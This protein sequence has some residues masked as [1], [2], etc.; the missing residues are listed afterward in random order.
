MALRI[1]SKKLIRCLLLVIVANMITQV[2]FSQSVGQISGGQCVGNT[3][4][5]LFTGS[6]TVSSWD[7]S[8]TPTILFTS[9]DKKNIQVKWS[10]A[11]IKSVSVNFSGCAA[12][13]LSP[14]RTSVTLINAVVPTLS[15]TL[16]R[17]TT[18]CPQGQVTFT[19]SGQNH[20]AANY[21]W[22]VDG[23]S[24]GGG[25][26][27]SYI[28]TTNLPSGSH[29]VYCKMTS[30]A[31][32]ADP[33][34]VSTELNPTS[35][36]VP[37][38][39]NYNVTV[40]GQG[41]ICS[42]NLVQSFFA[43]VENK[44]PGASYQWYNTGTPID[45]L[46]N[47]TSITENLRD[48]T[49][50][51]GDIITC[52]VSYSDPAN[53]CTFSK[54]SDSYLVNPISSPSPVVGINVERLEF[55]SDETIKFTS[56]KTA[57][58]YEWKIN[59]TN[60][61][62]AREAYLP[63]I[64]LGTSFVTLTV[65][66]LIE[67]CLSLPNSA[68]AS[69][70]GAP[71]KVFSRPDA[72]ASNQIIC[73]GDTFSSLVTNPNGVIGTFYTWSVTQDNVTGAIGGGGT[74]LSQPISQTLAN[75]NGLI[76]GKATYTIIP[77][78]NSCQGV[79]VTF[80]VTVQPMADLACLNENFIITN[81]LLIKDIIN[82]SSIV[83]LT[84]DQL[85]QSIQY[86]DGIGRQIQLVNTQGSPQKNDLVQPM[87]YDPLGR[88][89]FR[90]LPYVSSTGKSGSIKLDFIPKEDANYSTL[91]N[92][93]YKFYQTTP[94]IAF[95]AKPYSETVFEPSPLNRVLKQ[96]SP[97]DVW[98]PT[99]DIYS[100]A[101]NTI[102]KRSLVNSTNDKIRIF[103]LNPTTGLLNDQ[104]V[105]YN[106]LELYVDVTFDE[107]NNEVS[108]F[109]DKKGHVVCKKVQYGT[110]NTVVPP[111]ALHASTYY[112]YDD[113]GNLIMVLPPEAVK[114]LGN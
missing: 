91:T 44:P 34:F 50:K 37:S 16:N 95:D 2:S 51:K 47:A 27:S 31:N 14:A 18:V 70:A 24:V 100:L 109:T 1:T 30:G 48:Y 9:S 96:G 78:V 54:N 56:S 102:K 97:G 93:Q 40:R 53:G 15:V 45:F 99:G 59:G 85:G 8:P 19:A 61:S 12:S 67:T 106:E 11:G 25:G 57:G 29:S 60:F 28:Y 76:D 110:D 64:S 62:N 92:P 86:F 73:S 23:L 3:Q 10:S 41:E 20:G 87:S 83:S 55:C 111:K 113:F 46:T 72:K 43:V 33:I 75:L 32:C 52:T 66:G 17:T 103:I 68:S 13:G 101:D 71:I 21:S 90:Y 107:H 80:I 5:F 65:T 49:V 74:S 88:E 108:T 38:S 7:F 39:L 94:N 89:V 105:F 42:N 82:E 98:K 6:C 81:S 63:A 114:A 104:V 36:Y 69:T 58:T 22:Y 112:L 79:P 35:F 26:S 4:Y 84:V 77:Y